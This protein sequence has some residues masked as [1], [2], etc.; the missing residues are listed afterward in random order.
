MTDTESRWV[1]NPMPFASHM[2]DHEALMWQLEKDPWFDPS[3]SS[4]AICEEPIDYEDFVRRLRWAIVNTPRLRERVIPT[5]GKISTPEWQL[6]PEFELNYHIRR[7]ALAGDGTRRDLFDLAMLLHQDPFD[8][9]RPLWRVVIIEG[10]EHGQSALMIKMHHTI[11][12][13]IGALK[14]AEFYMQGSARDELPPEVDFDDYE[15]VQSESE[16]RTG[17]VDVL[18]SVVGEIAT[19]GADPLRVVDIGNTV[20]SSAQEAIG[21]V[22]GESDH[23]GCSPLFVN[24]S[25]RRRLDTIAIDLGKAKK[26]ATR[27]GGT[28]NDVFLTAVAEGAINYHQDL[29]AHLDT[30]SMTFVISTREKGDRSSNA[31]VPVRLPIDAD[32]LTLRQRFNA[33]SG[34]ASA[35]KAQRSSNTSSA[36]IGTVAT[37]LPTSLLTKLARRQTAGI[38]IATSNLRAAPFEVFISGAKLLETY[39]L[40]P[41]AGTAANITAMSYNGTLYVGIVSDPASITDPE[42]FQRNIQAAFD[43]LF[44]LRKLKAK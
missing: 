5:M 15:P 20:V 26:A 12:D 27:L 14:M 23:N 8:R 39:P 21:D 18:R 13:G 6:D 10:L 35:Q 34:A 22:F 29:G 40:G 41:V 2:S 38:D 19:W 30:L 24:R 7:I 25:R 37:R 32:N 4:I 28:I 16:H 44:R 3:G 43:G 36:V 31:F 1:V 9:S 42:R 11:A 17:L 33:V